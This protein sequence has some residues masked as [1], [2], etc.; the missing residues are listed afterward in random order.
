[1]EQSEGQPSHFNLLPF[2]LCCLWDIIVA[3]QLGIVL[4]SLQVALWQT[5]SGKTP[6][7]D[8]L[9]RTHLLWLGEQS[10]DPSGHTY[11]NI[12]RI[13]TLNLYPFEGPWSS[14][15]DTIHVPGWFQR[16]HIRNREWHLPSLLE[17]VALTEP[18]ALAL[19]AF[20]ACGGKSD[21][22]LAAYIRQ[23]RGPGTEV[24]V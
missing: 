17:A 20:T 14:C 1:M 5:C 15:S 2:N 23:K 9:A 6:C 10:F 7:A 3:I 19:L 18:T 12:F 8:V 4:L 21:Q 22:C 16:S 11:L 13:H 24:R